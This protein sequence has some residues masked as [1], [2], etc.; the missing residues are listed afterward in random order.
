MDTLA[1]PARRIVDNAGCSKAGRTP[2]TIPNHQRFEQL[3]HRFPDWLAAART[4]GI[5]Q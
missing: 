4:A 3:L 1:V 5:L 2:Q